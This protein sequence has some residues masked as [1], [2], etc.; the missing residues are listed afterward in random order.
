MELNHN[1]AS[2]CFPTVP[3]FRGQS[4]LERGDT[5]PEPEDR[6]ERGPGRLDAVLLERFGIAA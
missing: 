2:I 3:R 6:A 5:A 4:F 1:E